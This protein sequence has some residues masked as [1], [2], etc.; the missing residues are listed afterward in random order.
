MKLKIFILLSICLFTFYLNAQSTDKGRIGLTYSLNGGCSV[1]QPNVM[2][3]GNDDIT[4][5]NGIGLIYLKPINNWL[6]WETGLTYTLYKV[7]TTSSPTP[8]VYTHNSTIS[9]LDIP[10]GVRA[11]FLKYFFANGGLLLDLDMMS[12]SPVSAQTGLGLM[13]GFGI[14]YDFNFGGSIFFNPY[15]KLHSLLPFGLDSQHER[16]LESGW[17]FGV[18]YKL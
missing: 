13:L 12:N 11:S 5:A 14:K 16:I 4:S 15:G 10:V 8:E 1:L 18:T 2:G 3:G 7:T 9:L 6:E 17:K